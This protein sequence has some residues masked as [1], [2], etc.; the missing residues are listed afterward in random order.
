MKTPTPQQFLIWAAS[1]VGVTLVTMW[2]FVGENGLLA[3]KALANEYTAVQAQFDAVENC[4][5]V[6]EW[7]IHRLNT[8][9]A[10]LESAIEDRLWM[11]PPDSKIYL[12][13][14]EL[15]ENT[16]SGRLCQPL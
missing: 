13:A 16:K 9:P 10:V 14:D 7:Q 2:S 12:F 3:R 6:L 1:V 4:N 8:R 5:R 11:A 15:A